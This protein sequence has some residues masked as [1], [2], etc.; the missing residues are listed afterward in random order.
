MDALLLHLREKQPNLALRRNVCTEPV[1]SITLGVVNRR[2]EGFGISHAT[3]DDD[4]CLLRL[5]L[6]LCKDPSIRGTPPDD[7]TSICLNVDYA[8]D[9]HIDRYNYGRSCV[10]AGGEYTAGELFLADAQGDYEYHVQRD[11]G[12]LLLHK[13]DFVR[14]NLHDINKTWFSFEGSKPHAVQPYQG[15]RISVVFFSVPPE[16]ITPRDKAILQA[17]G[18]PM[19]CL[20][21]RVALQWPLPFTIFICSTGRSQEIQNKSLRLLLQVFRVPENSIVLCVRN[22]DVPSYSALG[23]ALLVID[24]DFG[25]PEQRDLC[26]SARPQG[27]WNLFLDDDVTE[28]LG[29]EPD[30]FVPVILG[31][32]LS[33]ERANIRLFGFNTSA[34]PLNLRHTAS[35]QLGLVN[36]YFFGLIRQRDNPCLVVSPHLAGAAEDIE[37]SIVFFRHSGILRPTSFLL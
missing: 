13:N 27:S 24:D 34:N 31:C 19:L 2:A 18:F 22:V 5:L 20:K 35:R 6:A 30:D 36:G 14:G 4:F 15:F 23:L 16:K 10:V 33:C 32:F 7:Y 25:L 28:I 11:T 21:P 17:I 9:L 1:R 37:R 8:A 26:I 29:L 3:Y 12:D